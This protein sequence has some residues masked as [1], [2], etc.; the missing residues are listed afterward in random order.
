MQKT[1]ETLG[2]RV[3]RYFSEG[4]GAAGARVPASP[5]V[6]DLWARIR[7]AFWGVFAVMLLLSLIGR[8]AE[9]I[10]D[11]AGAT[12][13]AL[14]SILSSLLIAL[15]VAGL[16]VSLRALIW[17]LMRRSFGRSQEAEVRGWPRRE[18][19]DAIKTAEKE[20]SMPG[21]RKQRQ[22]RR[23]IAWLYKERERTHGVPIPERMREDVLSLAGPKSR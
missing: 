3:A 15:G 10:D 18:F 17:I 2:R 23:Y 9:L 12:E 1:G 21:A 13:V 14:F 22:Y 16:F 19:D 7:P 11:P 4:V 5:A 20:A 8:S 6:V